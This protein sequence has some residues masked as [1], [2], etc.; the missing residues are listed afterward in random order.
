MSRRSAR[1][2]K[3]LA[4]GS[5]VKVCCNDKK[6]LL[7]DMGI[8][9]PGGQVLK[10]VWMYGTVQSVSK[11]HFSVQLPAAEE[12]IAIV[13]EKVFETEEE[14]P[15]AL[16]VLFDD[17]TI[18]EVHGLSLPQNISLRTIL[19]REKRLEKRRKVES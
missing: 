2:A 11:F 14:D 7:E 16:H 17:G 12:T 8:K 3:R 9:G 4:V 10:D 6:T 15:D 13:K 5:R 18:K 19:K 1:S